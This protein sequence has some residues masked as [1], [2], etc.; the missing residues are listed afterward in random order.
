MDTE[1]KNLKFYTDPPKPMNRQRTLNKKNTAGGITIP[2]FH[3]PE[4]S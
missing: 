2:D 3:I 4:P 1:K